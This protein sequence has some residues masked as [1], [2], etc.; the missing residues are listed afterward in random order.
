MWLVVI[1]CA[2]ATAA[3]SVQ[4]R[5]ASEELSPPAAQRSPEDAESALADAV[6]P[7]ESDEP[8]VDFFLDV[9]PILIA[10][11]HKCHGSEMHRSGLR[12]DSRES[13]ERGGDSGR[14]VL[15]GTP[16]TNELWARVSSSD[17]AYRMPKNAPPL[18]QEEIAIL[19]RWVEQGTPW[20]V[21]SNMRRSRPFYERWLN[22]SGSLAD[23]YE[24]EYTY[25]LPYV[26]GMLACY[27]LLLFVIRAQAA[28]RKGRPWTT[29]RLAGFCRFSDRVKR[30]ELLLVMALSFLGLALAVA[31]GHVLKIER[32]LAV[33]TMNRARTESPWSHSP[34]GRPPKPIR[35][36]HPKQVAGT[37]YRGN[38]ERNPELFNGGN[39]LTAIFRV[40]LCDKQHR[41]LDVGH[42]LPADGLFVRVEIE[43]AP[44]ATELLFSKELMASV[45]LVKNFY[46]DPNLKLLE[47]PVRLKTLEPEKRWVAF[48]PIGMPDDQ[49]T[50]SGVI[51]IYTG[52]IQDDMLRGSLHYGVQYEL[53]FA[54]GGLSPESDLWMD[55]FGNA[56]VAQPDPPGK[57]PYR[58]WFDDRP[59]PVISG[60]N[61]KDPKLL[62]V[63][64][65]VEEGL[66]EPDGEAKADQDPKPNPPPQSQES[67][68]EE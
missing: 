43:R 9:Q 21:P 57:L 3:A 28:Y 22:Y 16:E 66:I 53:R 13:A 5:E 45:L 26:I 2:A 40:S 7:A 19:R 50:L 61:S 10:H 54:G 42:A 29:G 17:R 37:Y 23:R 41:Q 48:V 60:E 65:Y 4:P 44:G 47:K 1:A 63:D 27:F 31:R 52:R 49:A 38:C 33:A 8:A 20:Q 34:Y 58:E 64:Q 25:A 11:C 67:R 35:G 14:P 24:P 62:G 36:D 68:D 12:L 55:S 18:S 15:G 30:R 56:A 32:E 39:Y 59:I 6:P 51:Y 46:E